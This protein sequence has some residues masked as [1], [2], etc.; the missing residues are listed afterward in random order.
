MEIIE[1]LDCAW[2]FNYL[3]MTQIM[4]IC[5]IKFNKIFIINDRVRSFSVEAVGSSFILLLFPRK[6]LKVSKNRIFFELFL[7]Q[8]KPELILNSIYLAENRFYGL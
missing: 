3:N 8:L 6:G 4:M 7:L 2:A 1:G 5:K